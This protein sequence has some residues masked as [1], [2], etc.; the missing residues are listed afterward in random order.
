M[1]YQV[2]RIVERV[3][4]TGAEGVP[5][6]QKNAKSPGTPAQALQGL[7]FFSRLQFNGPAVGV[8]LHTPL[9]TCQSIVQLGSAPDLPAVDHHVL[10]LPAHLT[11]GRDHGGGAQ[12]PGLL[13][14]AAFGGV[15]QLLG[16]NDRSS[17]A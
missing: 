14:L 10:V 17:T 11:D 13:Q 6:S 7:A 16:G 3:P 9:N 8:G 1:R 15:K 2:V 5:S 4:I 12:C